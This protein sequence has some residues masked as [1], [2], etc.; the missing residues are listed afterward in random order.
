MHCFALEGAYD[1]MSCHMEIHTNTSGNKG[2][3]L[4]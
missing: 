2:A 1:H 3:I 4:A